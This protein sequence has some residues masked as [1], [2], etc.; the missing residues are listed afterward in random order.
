MITQSLMTP[1]RFQFQVDA[2]TLRILLIAATASISFH[3][4]AVDSATRASVAEFKRTVEKQVAGP[5]RLATLARF[6][7]ALRD[8]IVSLPTPPEETS[9]QDPRRRALAS[10]YEFESYLEQI[11]MREFS[12]AECQQ[13]DVAIRAS[14][15]GVSQVTPTRVGSEAA[16]ALSMVRSLC[17]GVG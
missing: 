8:R 11:D 4:D 7:S 15:V 1:L 3:A 16:L 5:D 10:L 13:Q 6:K 12:R 2:F 9:A 14:A 17:H